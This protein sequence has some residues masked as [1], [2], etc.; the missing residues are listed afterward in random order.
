[1]QA[2]DRAHRIGQQKPVTV[3]RILVKGTVEDRIMEL[4]ERKRNLVEA[5]LNEQA[6]Q[7]LGRLNQQDLMYLF[8]GGGE[9]ATAARP[10]V[11]GSSPAPSP[12]PRFE[13]GRVYPVDS[14]SPM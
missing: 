1:M 2:V 5:A 6:S 3:H 10:N 12:P 8:N 4:Q 7:G 14:P 11:Y 13:S 9:R